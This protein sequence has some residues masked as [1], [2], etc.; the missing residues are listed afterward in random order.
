M[1]RHSILARGGMAPAVLLAGLG[2]LALAGCSSGVQVR[3]NLPDEEA[4]SKISEGVHSRA[5]IESL[6]G[7]PSTISF[8]Q[9]SKWYYIGQK[10]TEFAFFAPEVLER[11]ILAV[12]FDETGKVSETKTYTI[13]D[14]Q[15]ID[16][17]DRVTPTEGR[18]LS[19]MQQLFGNIGRFSTEQR[20]R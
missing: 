18:E 17:V 14:G 20:E 5:D 15:E 8:F 4:V 7:S 3:G 11:K 2:A 16:P 13:E 1:V 19:L 10:T 12:S 9:D 6:L